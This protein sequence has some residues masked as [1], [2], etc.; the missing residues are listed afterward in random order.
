MTGNPQIRSALFSSKRNVSNLTTLILLLTDVAAT[1]CWS[2]GFGGAKLSF[3]DIFC[4]KSINCHGVFSSPKQVFSPLSISLAK[5]SKILLSMAPM[6]PL[7][8]SMD[9]CF[10]VITRQQVFPFHLLPTK[11]KNLRKHKA[12]FLK[13]NAVIKRCKKIISIL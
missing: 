12:H 10:C 4:Q 7:T 11:R 9:R 2:L 3:I 13:L 6:F 8:T 1:S 5:S